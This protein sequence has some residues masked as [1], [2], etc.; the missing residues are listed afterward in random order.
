M[1]TVGSFARGYSSE[2]MFSSAYSSTAARIWSTYTSMD[3]ESLLSLVVMHSTPIRADADATFVARLTHSLRRRY[4]RASCSASLANPLLSPS[5]KR[6]GKY[7]L[8][9]YI[10]VYGRP[11]GQ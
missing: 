8:Y 9:V 6:S 1:I 4:H 11:Y 5:V 10:Y 2:K 7:A 3:S